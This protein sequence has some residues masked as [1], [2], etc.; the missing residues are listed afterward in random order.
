VR[1]VLRSSTSEASGDASKTK[2]LYNIVVVTSTLL[3]LI[4]VVPETD[5]FH[6]ASC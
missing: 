5:H 3:A 4:G 1:D 6:R 2:R